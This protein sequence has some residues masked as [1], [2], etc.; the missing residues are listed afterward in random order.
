MAVAVVQNLETPE[1]QRT[2]AEGVFGALP[3]EPK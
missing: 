3:N 2:A 1:Q